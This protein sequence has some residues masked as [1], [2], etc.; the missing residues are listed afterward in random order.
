MWWQDDPNV[1]AC[2][3]CGCPIQRTPTGTVADG[4]RLHVNTVHPTAVSR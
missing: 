1:V 3:L 2:E 4:L